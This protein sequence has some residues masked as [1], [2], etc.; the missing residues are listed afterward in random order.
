MSATIIWR[1]AMSID[2]RIATADESLD[3]LETISK[4]AQAVEDFGAFLRTI[5]GIIV[6]AGTLR[7]LIRGGHGWPHGD[8]RTWLV[9]HDESLIAQVGTTE[10]PF[11]RIA[12]DVGALVKEVD[13]AGCERVWLAGGGALAGQLLEIDRIDEIDATIAPVA[14]GAGPSLFGDRPLPLRPFQLKEAR[15]LADNAVLAR[16]SRIRP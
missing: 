9:S 15:S 11:R 1:T 3:F 12:G 4:E 8:I 7:W 5:D 10:K 16:W 14:L 6:G 13:A 2:G